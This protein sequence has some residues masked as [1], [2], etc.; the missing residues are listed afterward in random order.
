MKLT[1]YTQKDCPWCERAK[2]LAKLVGHDY[3]EVNQKHED[4]P[5]V[6][7]ILMDDSPI[8]GFIEYSQWCRKNSVL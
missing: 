8:G 3:V 6:P 2:G 5:T 4:W 1:I 7:Y